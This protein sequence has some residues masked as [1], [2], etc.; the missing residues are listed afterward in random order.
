MSKTTDAIETMRA[1]GFDT[2]Q[3]IDALCDGE[4]LTALGLDDEDQA[5]IEDAVADLRKL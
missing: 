1:E 5:D 4:A 2:K 3:I